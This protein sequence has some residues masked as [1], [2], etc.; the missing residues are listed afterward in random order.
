MT[1]A[2]H[3]YQQ[4]GSQQ[5]CTT[6]GSQ[7]LKRTLRIAL[8]AIVMPTLGCS[9]TT[10]VVADQS[11]GKRLDDAWVSYRYEFESV[12]AYKSRSHCKRVGSVRT[13]SDG[14]AH[15]ATGVPTFWG[16][17]TY[18]Y[19]AYKPGYS[20]KTNIHDST[21]VVH[22]T[23]FAG[24]P[25]ERIEQL[26]AESRALACRFGDARHSVQLHQAV[27]KEAFSLTPHLNDDPKALGLVKNLCE[28]LCFAATGPI[29]P[30]HHSS[31][32]WRRTCIDWLAIN[33]QS[34]F[35]DR[36]KPS[37]MPAKECAVPAN[38]PERC[39]SGWYVTTC[40]RYSQ[41]CRQVFEESE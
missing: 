13:N 3:N 17:G 41:N 21:G 33:S 32:A 24:S 35:A 8:L 7:T 5:S 19:T 36:T 12:L 11:T 22:L 23:P 34:C 20:V 27:I 28:E 10:F 26:A 9:Q 4:I 38:G 16:K 18:R 31:D 29:D 6:L 1:H 14:E 2:R 40:D 37:R 15:L 30:N 39:V 25:S